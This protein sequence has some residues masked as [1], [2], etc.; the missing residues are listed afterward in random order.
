MFPLIRDPA[1]LLSSIIL[2]MHFGVPDISKEAEFVLNLIWYIVIS[3][4]LLR[5]LNFILKGL[6]VY[7]KILGLKG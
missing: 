4:L 2:K 3:G 6:L 5:S 7:P 1:E